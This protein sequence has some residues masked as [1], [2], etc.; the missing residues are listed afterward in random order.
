MQGDAKAYIPSPRSPCMGGEQMAR[1]MG[2]RSGIVIVAALLLVAV[3]PATAN[4]HTSGGE[5]ISSCSAILVV[6][7]TTGQHT[8]AGTE[9]R[10]GFSWSTDTH[11][12]VENRLQWTGGS[13]VLTCELDGPSFRCDLTGSAPAPGTTVYHLCRETTVSLGGSWTCLFEHTADGSTN[14]ATTMDALADPSMDLHVVTV[15]LAP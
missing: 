1:G 8:V 10:L 12:T 15:P 3:V 9:V 7:C 13:L 14:A 2:R 6:P 5:E 11:A 4:A